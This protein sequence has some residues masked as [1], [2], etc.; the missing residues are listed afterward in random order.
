MSAKRSRT[1][2]AKPKPEA[3]GVER[4]R[5]VFIEQIRARGRV[6]HRAVLAAM[7]ECLEHPATE[8]MQEI[9]LL[10]RGKLRLW[11]QKV[12]DLEGVREALTG[13]SGA[14]EASG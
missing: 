7:R 4:L 11:P 1:R 9:A 6:H 13:E 5:Q 14:G 8:R 3:A 10:L 12:N 2:N